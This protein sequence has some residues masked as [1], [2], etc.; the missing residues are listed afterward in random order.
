MGNIRGQIA[1]KEYRDNTKKTGVHTRLGRIR[2]LLWLEK[3]MQ[4]QM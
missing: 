3:E 2:E 1:V 4:V